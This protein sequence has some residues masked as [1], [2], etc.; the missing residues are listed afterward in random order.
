MKTIQLNAPAVSSHQARVNKSLAKV[1]IYLTSMQFVI[2]MT[3]VAFAI[4]YVGLLTDRDSLVAYG[5]LTFLASFA[6]YA[7][8]DTFK[9]SNPAN[10]KNV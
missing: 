9:S 6:P 1:I 10:Q 7:I 3:V 8:R 5:T 2:A 4:M